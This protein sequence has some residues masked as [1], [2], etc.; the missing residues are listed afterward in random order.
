M[1][2]GRETQSLSLL[3]R[4]SR[5]I[6]AHA[7]GLKAVFGIGLRYSHGRGQAPTSGKINEVALNLGANVSF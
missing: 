5:V 2:A 1:N 7:V 4:L 6:A 3:P